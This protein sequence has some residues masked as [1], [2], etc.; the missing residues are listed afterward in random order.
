MTA[1][2]AT[3]PHQTATGLSYA[4]GAAS[5][6]DLTAGQRAQVKVPGERTRESALDTSL[7]ANRT[8]AVSPMGGRGG[9]QGPLPTPLIGADSDTARS[10]RRGRDP[11]ALRHG[12]R[13]ACDSERAT[14]GK[15]G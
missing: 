15:H 5:S 9:A 7:P 11:G 3:A 13:S 10:G 12:M 8:A 6:A 14:T 4:S 2:A 1:E